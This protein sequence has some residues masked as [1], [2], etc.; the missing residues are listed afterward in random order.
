MNIEMSIS[1][2][3]YSNTGGGNTGGGERYDDTEIKKEIAAL[4]SQVAGLTAIKPYNDTELKQEVSKLKVEI[5]TIRNRYKEYQAGYIPRSGFK[6]VAE[7]NTFMTIPFSKSFSKRP[8]V[9]ITLDIASTTVRM[10]YQA[11]A[12]TTGFDIATNYAGSLDGVWYE[13]YIID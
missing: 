5:E 6:S 7:N 10:T 3:G 9:K 1:G 13:A 2:L 4:R 12:T 8:F 11:N